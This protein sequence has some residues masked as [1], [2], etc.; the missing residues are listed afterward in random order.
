MADISALCV[1]IHMYFETCPCEFIKNVSCHLH[2]GYFGI[3]YCIVKP[4]FCHF[5]FDGNN[6]MIIF[7][8]G[9]II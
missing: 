5:L 1:V 7:I 3:F 6:N 9:M 4:F 8:K 2:F